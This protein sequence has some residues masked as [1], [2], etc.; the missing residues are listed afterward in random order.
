[1]REDDIRALLAAVAGGELS[2]DEA[3]ER[4]ARLP[5][6]DLG[7]AKLD[8]HRELRNGVP[9][10]VLAEGKHEGD[11][12]R[13]AERLAT[14]H[15][16]LLMTRVT[17]RQAAAVLAALPEAR[18]DERARVLTLGDF[19]APRRWRTAVLCAGTSDLPVAAEAAACAAW[20]GGDVVRHHDVGI[21]GIHRLV[22]KLEEI[23]TA[24]VLVVAAGMDGALPTLVAS[25]VRAPV[26]AV[27]T[28]VGYGSSFD[29]LAALLT[30]LNA[31][32]PGVAV[33]NIDNG[34]GAAMLAYRIA[35]SSSIASP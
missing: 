24:E 16:R 17:D 18:H 29:G 21:A 9:E 6:A 2:Q 19:E 27:P 11:L 3:V 25:L 26:V 22:A 1:M 28:S 23:R 34:Y 20:M 10:A 8:L 31:C 15:G 5:F 13:I 32:S 33:V 7:E 35:F 4:L 12:V 30:M 14:E